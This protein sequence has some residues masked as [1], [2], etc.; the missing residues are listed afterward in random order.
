[1][2]EFKVMI[3]D[4]LVA[5]LGSEA[6]EKSLQNFVDR[7]NLKAAAQDAL[8]GLHEIDLESDPQWQVAREEA[9]KEYQTKK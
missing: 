9:W 7:L 3:E 1:M 5:T 6:I 2:T 8:A 4:K